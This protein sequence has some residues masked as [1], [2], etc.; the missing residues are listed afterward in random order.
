MVSAGPDELLPLRGVRVVEIAGLGPLPLC[1]M[2]LADLG[3]SVIRI[4][5]PRP[6]EKGVGVDTSRSMLHRGRSSTAIDLKSESRPR[7]FACDG[8][9]RRHSLGRDE[10]RCHG[11]PRLRSD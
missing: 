2:L 4:D 3:A 1:A 7:S 6:T 5:Q 11:T 8:G 10:A 9:G